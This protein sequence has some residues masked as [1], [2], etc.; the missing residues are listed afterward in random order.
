MRS[1]KL[2]EWFSRKFFEISGAA[3]LHR[4]MQEL[5]TCSK[6]LLELDAQTMC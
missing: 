4:Q 5:V 6:T 1:V 2:Q 3:M